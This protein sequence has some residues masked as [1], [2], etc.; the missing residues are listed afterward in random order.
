MKT[1]SEMG[2]ALPL[3]KVQKHLLAEQ[4]YVGY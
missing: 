2:I 1:E 4:L 3:S